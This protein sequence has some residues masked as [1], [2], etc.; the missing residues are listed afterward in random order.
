MFS[1]VR[2]VRTVVLR[3]ALQT[4][5]T[6]YR[7]RSLSGSVLRSKRCPRWCYSAGLPLCC[8]VLY[9]CLGPRRV[10]AARHRDWGS[11]CDSV[12]PPE[13]TN[14]STLHTATMTAVLI[15][16]AR[17]S[18]W[19]AHVPCIIAVQ[20]PT[21]ASPGSV[22]GAPTNNTFMYLRC[23]AE[24][25]ASHVTFELRMCCDG[26]ACLVHRFV[27]MWPCPCRV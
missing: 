15:P 19:D 5:C 18:L 26:G 16:T 11:A 22:D 2:W 13:V 9:T 25:R 20:C 24:T 12:H 23:L 8:V 17:L 6:V 14:W 4:R 3:A 1:S 27:D 7:K 21:T 10:F